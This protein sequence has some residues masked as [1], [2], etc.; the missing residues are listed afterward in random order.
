[1][2]A[3]LLQLFVPCWHHIITIVL[4]TN[5]MHHV[6]SVNFILC[7]CSDIISWKGVDTS[8]NQIQLYVVTLR[9]SSLEV[10][11]VAFF[12]GW[13]YNTVLYSEGSSSVSACYLSPADSTVSQPVNLEHPCRFDWGRVLWDYR[14]SDPAEIIK[15]HLQEFMFIYAAYL[16][17]SESSCLLSCCI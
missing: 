13:T 7:G 9:W 3:H 1:M 5:G 2:V 4:R 16:Y 14:P 12:Q 15:S 17:G 8:I 10:F 6:C 11:S